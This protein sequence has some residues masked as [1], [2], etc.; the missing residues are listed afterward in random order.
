MLHSTRN[1]DSR[2]PVIDGNE[3]TR[4]RKLGERNLHNENIAPTSGKSGNKMSGLLPHPRTRFGSRS[5][6]TPFENRWR[7]LPVWE[8]KLKG[9]HFNNICK[10][11][12]KFMRI[13]YPSINQKLGCRGISPVFTRG[14]TDAPA[15]TCLTFMNDRFVLVATVTRDL[16]R[17]RPGWRAFF[18]FS[19]F[20]RIFLSQTK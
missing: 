4:R 11:D 17:L 14:K 13:G 3:N 18:N 16:S 9:W 2:T 15:S 5:C 19:S 7:S 12:G 1:F 10:A 6:K 8:S 20:R